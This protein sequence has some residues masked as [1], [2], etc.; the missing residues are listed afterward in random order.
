MKIFDRMKTRYGVGLWGVIAIL[1]AFSL[2]GMTVARVRQPILNFILPNN[3][4]RWATWAIYPF[5]LI[6]TYQV[7]LLAY[8]SVL[9]QFKFFW[10]RLKKT[11]RFLFGW[12]L[13]RSQ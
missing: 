4:P 9:G 1:L 12:M 3:S 2:A 6:P 10:S 5:I 7:L 11:W 8:G 13:P